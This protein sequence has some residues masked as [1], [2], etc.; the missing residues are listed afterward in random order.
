M[1]GLGFGK[2]NKQEITKDTFGSRVKDLVV[3]GLIEGYSHND[4]KRTQRNSCKSGMQLES[5]KPNSVNT[6]HFI[7]YS[8]YK[9]IWQQNY[10]Q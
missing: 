2:G 8:T 10:V 4:L 7:T 6:S 3:K 5:Q 9:N 1:T